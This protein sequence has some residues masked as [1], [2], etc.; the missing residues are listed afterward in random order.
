MF[1]NCIYFIGSLFLGWGLGANDSAN[2][3][4]TA[5]SSKLVSYRIAVIC[6]AV[7]VIAGAVIQGSAGIKTLSFSLSRQ[8]VSSEKKIT[9]NTEYRSQ[10][11]REVY[12]ITRHKGLEKAMILS[13]A[14]AF[15]VFIMTLIKLPVSTS[16]AIVGSIIGVGIMDRNVNFA[17]LEKV[18]LCW[19]TTPLGGIIFT[20]IFY[21]LFK[22]IFRRISI[23]IFNYDILM[24]FL[25]IVAGCYGAYALGANNAA[26]VAAVFVKHGILTVQQAAWFGGI[27]IAFGVVTYSKPVMLTV[28][29]DIIKLDAFM[30]FIT[31]LSLAV[32]VYVYALIGVPVSTTQAIVG[33]VIGFGLI[34]GTQTVKL[35]TLK[36]ILAGWIITPI[37]GGIFSALGYFISNLYYIR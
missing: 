34:K 5:V 10:S 23:S 33:A 35:N 28:G 16:Q 21:F 24:R 12:E 4:G 17:G 29:K 3:F 18:V 25:L 22:N 7:F 11:S 8:N 13:F 36:K 2:V 20:L 14:A 32:T 9:I 1:S 15:S 6:T 30:A 27:A 26:N 37:I 19:V 31:V